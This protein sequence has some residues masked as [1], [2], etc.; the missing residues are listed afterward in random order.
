MRFHDQ[1]AHQQSS[2][3]AYPVAVDLRIFLSFGSSIILCKQT[4]EH[5]RVGRVRMVPIYVRCGTKRLGPPKG[6][7]FRPGDR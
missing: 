4:L 3:H 5:W 1:Q 2:L 7:I 6:F